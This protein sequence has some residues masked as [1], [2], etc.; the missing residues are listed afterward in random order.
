SFVT[1]MIYGFIL[2]TCMIFGDYIPAVSIASRLVLY[3]IGLLLCV[4][5][6]AFMFHTYFSPSAYELFVK[7]VSAQK[8]VHINR[9]KTL[10]DYVS[11]LIGIIL[12]FVFFGFFR[13]E[14]V[15]IGTIVC[16]LVNGKLIGL[17]SDWMEKH[18]EFH[19]LLPW[20]RF[21]QSAD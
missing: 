19:D 11:C 6:V 7:E 9:F 12:S 3:I 1:T 2:N 21:F 15:K 8:H 16:A 4:V 13:F 20:R 17:C 14:G 18:W 10:Y 5:A